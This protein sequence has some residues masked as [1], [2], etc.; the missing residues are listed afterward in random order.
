MG[1]VYYYIDSNGIRKSIHTG[2]E[3]K[4]DV[5][6][7]RYCLVSIKDDKCGRSNPPPKLKVEGRRRR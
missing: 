1:K 4:G 2:R 7:D 3:I 5:S 6:N